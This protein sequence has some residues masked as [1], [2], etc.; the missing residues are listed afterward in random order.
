[1]RKQ[2][3]PGL[4]GAA[5]ISLAIFVAA[6]CDMAKFAAGSTVDV[7]VRGTPS[8]MEE[9]DTV[10]AEAALVSNL[11]M[12]EGLLVILG[13]KDK[14]LLESLAMGFGS[15]AFGYLDPRI[16]SIAD[17]NDPTRMRLVWRALNYYARAKHYGELHLAKFDKDLPAKLNGDVETIKAALAEIDPKKKKNKHLA[18]G[19]FWIG[20]SWANMINLQVD[21]PLPDGAPYAMGMLEADPAMAADSGDVDTGDIS[22]DIDTGDVS[23]EVALDDPVEGGALPEEGLPKVKLILEKTI[24]LDESYFNAAALSVLGVV[25]GAVPPALGGNPDEAL[26]YFDRALVVTERKFLLNQVFK[27]QF[28][29]TNAG[30]RAAFDA[31]LKEVM[32]APHDLFPEETLSN[33][34]AKE[35]AIAL[36]KERDTLFTDDDMTPSMPAPAAAAGDKTPGTK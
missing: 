13:P 28:W 9:P 17:P 24:E 33:M 26:V 30:D 4:T 25:H 31:L 7:L 22:G 35:R 12:L 18:I 14:D 3:G 20:Y 32:D 6:G 16:E 29:A 8:V 21:N 5:V 27:A 15:Y 36:M 34:L 23:G 11:K 2:Q 19:L 1:M 10:L